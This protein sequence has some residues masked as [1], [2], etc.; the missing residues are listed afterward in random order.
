MGLRLVKYQ[1]KKPSWQGLALQSSVRFRQLGSSWG[2]ENAW[3]IHQAFL[4]LKFFTRR[5]LDFDFIQP[6]VD[7]LRQRVWIQTPPGLSE[8][9]R[10]RE[11]EMLTTIQRGAR[12]E[13]RRNTIANQG[14]IRL[15]P[16]ILAAPPQFVNASGKRVPFLVVLIHYE[17]H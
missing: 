16:G 12:I 15:I 7:H 4:L 11:S 8:Q 2:R 5:R 9:L 17:I 10:D 3:R 14:V 13:Q 1:Q 6:P